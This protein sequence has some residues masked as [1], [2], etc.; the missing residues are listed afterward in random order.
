MKKEELLEA[1]EICTGERACAGCP[2]LPKVLKG[3]WCMDML[4][5]ALAEEVKNSQGVEW[6]EVTKRPLTQEEKAYYEEIGNGV[7][8]TFDCEMPD[9]GQ[10]ILVATSWGVDTD[11]CYSDGCEFWLDNLGNLDGVLAWAE[12]PTYRKGRNDD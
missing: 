6:H 1:A 12:I 8:E 7:E 5:D 4:I 3:K 9:D 11:I 10:E 2:M